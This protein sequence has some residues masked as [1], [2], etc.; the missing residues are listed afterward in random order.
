MLNPFKS[1]SPGSSP[2]APQRASVSHVELPSAAEI[3]KRLR[4]TQDKHLGLLGRR[5]AL[6]QE[7][8]LRKKS[9]PNITAE[10]IAEFNRRQAALDQEIADTAE[11]KTA[12]KHQLNEARDREWIARKQ[13]RKAALEADG[14]ADDAL[15]EEANTLLH[16]LQKNLCK[17]RTR[18]IAY[19][20]FNSTSDSRVGYLDFPEFRIRHRA[21]GPGGIGG[22]GPRPLWVELPRIPM[23]YP[24]DGVLTIEIDKNLP[25]EVPPPKPLALDDEPPPPAALNGGRGSAFMHVHRMAVPQEPPPPET[26]FYGKPLARTA[27]EARA[28]REDSRDAAA[29]APP[30]LVRNVQGHGR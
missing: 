12:Q 10:V 16:A 18:H 15:Y 13:K 7:R 3:E 20:N 11:L 29:A 2:N 30:S 5:D 22:Y 19:E 9:D 4:E 1:A 24:G 8:E 25:A 14:K 26:D 21:P 27:D 17:Q 23:V 6:L 28:A